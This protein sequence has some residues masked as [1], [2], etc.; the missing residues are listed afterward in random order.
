MVLSKG[1]NYI[2]G[3]SVRKINNR[4]GRRVKVRFIQRQNDDSFV[5]F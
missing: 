3:H 4:T 1:I 5:L 2:T